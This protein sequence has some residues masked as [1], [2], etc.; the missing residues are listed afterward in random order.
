[1]NAGGSGLW[2]ALQEVFLNGVVEHTSSAHSTF[3][4][5]ANEFIVELKYVSAKFEKS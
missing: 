5:V 3:F 1:M 2:E 4:L